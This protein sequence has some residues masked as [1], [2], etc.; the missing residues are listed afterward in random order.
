LL[1]GIRNQAFNAQNINTR[2]L[3]LPFTIIT[4]TIS[5]N[6]NSPRSSLAQA[7][8]TIL[9][10][11]LPP[12]RISKMTKTMAVLSVSTPVLKKNSN[13]SLKSTSNTS[14]QQQQQQSQKAQQDAP[15]IPPSA[16]GRP[17]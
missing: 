16:L 11:S 5:N 12:T 3:L 6:N 15:L 2:A 7:N 9:P 1:F 8:T 17:F 4:I 13:M 10:Y 14:Q